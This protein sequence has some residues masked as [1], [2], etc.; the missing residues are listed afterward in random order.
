[1]PHV[2][3]THP[4]PLMLPLAREDRVTGLNTYACDIRKGAQRHGHD[5]QMT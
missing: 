5:S 3:D 2:Y 1:M 4:L